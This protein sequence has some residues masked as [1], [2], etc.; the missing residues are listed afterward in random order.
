MIKIISTVSQWHEGITVLRWGQINSHQSAFFDY[1]RSAISFADSFPKAFERF[2][3]R[4]AQRQRRS[5]KLTERAGGGGGTGYHGGLP[6][7]ILERQW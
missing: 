7:G 5:L 4:T 2:I 6:T 1:K 3:D